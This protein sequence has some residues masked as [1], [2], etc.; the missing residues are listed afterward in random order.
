M[1]KVLFFA[2]W[3]PHRYDAMAGLFVRKHAMAVSRYA[4][5]C[6]LFPYADEHISDFEIVTQKTENVL[7]IYVYFPFSKNRIL[8]KVSKFVNYF[9]A[10]DKGYSIVKKEFGKPDLT[11]TNVLTRA[12]MFS[13]FL[14]RKESIPYVIT[15]QWSRY[16]NEKD[17]YTN[18]IHKLVT[19]KIVCEATCVMPVSESLQQAMQN[20]GL[21]NQ[22]YQCV[23]NVVDDFFYAEQAKE[24]RMKKRILHV[25]CFDEK[26][27]NL[28]GILRVIQRLSDER[29]DFE[30]VVVGTGPDFDKIVLEASN[31]EILNSVVRFVGE[32]TPQ[33]VS[34]WMHQSDFFLLF[35]NYETFAT[36][37]PESLASGIPVVTSNVGIAK[38]IINETNGKIVSVGD[39]ESLYSEIN[40][41]LNHFQEF[42]K[43]QIRESAR[44][45][46]FE[47][48]GK[49]LNSVYSSA[50]ERS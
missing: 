7:E 28:L 44:Q 40:L 25:S 39:E 10:F 38:S 20:C 45:F 19:K 36:V 42:D 48:V 16:F 37:I 43:N 23:G 22:N 49:F 6:V 13:F 50:I 11:H 14:K 34:D 2:A 27:K 3:Y 33:Q 8:R 26:A 4:E 46:T 30:L 41:M 18:C 12:G 47:N 5:V 15:E 24:E 29:H 35:S 21:Q 9:R 32:Q 1:K 17:T 31:L